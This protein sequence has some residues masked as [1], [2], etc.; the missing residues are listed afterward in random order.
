MREPRSPASTRGVTQHIGYGLL[1]L[2]VWLAWEVLKAPVAARAPPSIGVR[3]AATSP[4]VLRRAAEAEFTAGRPGNAEALAEE[5]LVRA[6]FNARALRVRGLAAAEA[7]E[8]EQADQLLTLAGNWSLRDDPAHAWLVEYRLRQGDYASSFAHADTLARRR[9][10]IRP[11][12]FSLFT[13]AAASDPEALRAVANL[14]AAAPPWRGAYWSYLKGADQ[15]DE[16]LLSLAIALE[17]SASP[18]TQ[19]ELS[20]LYQ[21]WLGERRLAA[22][23][24][25]REQVR[26]P[27][28]ADLVLN[29]SFSGSSAEEIS[30]FGWKLGRSAGLTVEVVEDDRD[31]RNLALRAEYDGF[32]SAAIAEQVLTLS[33]GPYVFSADYRIESDAARASLWWSLVCIDDR[34][35]L[36]EA[37]ATGERATPGASWAAVRVDFT[38]PEQGCLVQRLSLTPRPADRRAPIAAWFDDV[39]ISGASNPKSQRAASAG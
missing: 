18:F 26:R 19:R 24:A 2:S 34:K 38:V 25:L 28:P 7:G 10:D 12:I 11:Q 3:I 9:T 1:A 8:T 5:S 23:G 30:P 31:S 20:W 36:A 14:L 6:P 15:G 29:G 27:A 22:I 39:D 37:R 32:G 21:R 33:P 13:T 35:Q 4:E 16:L 17:S